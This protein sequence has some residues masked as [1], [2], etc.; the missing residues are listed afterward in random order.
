MPRPGG[1]R[2]TPGGGHHWRW[3]GENAE[4]FAAMGLTDL[5]LPP[6]YKAASGDQS[7]GYDAYDLW[8]FGQFP[9]KGADES[10][11]TTQ[12]KYGD[13]HAFE[14]ALAALQKAG[15]GKIYLDAVLNHRLGADATETF[16]AHPVRDDNR[17]I[18]GDP[19]D[20]DGYT[21]FF[22]PKRIPD[23]TASI[24][25][26][27][28]SDEEP[29]STLQWT[30]NHFTG[31][32]YDQRTEKNQIFRIEGDGKSWAEDVDNENG[33]YDFLMG[34]DVDHAHPAVRKDLF[35]W[36]AWVLRTFPISGMRF[37]AVKHISRDFIR[38]F[39]HHSR[40]VSRDLRKERGQEPADE[41]GGPI[42]FS[43]GELWKDDVPTCLAYLEAFEAGDEGEQF[44]L[45]DA[46]LHYNFVEAGQQGKDYDLRKVFDNT[47]VQVRPRDAVTLVANHDTQPGQA[48][49]SVV[50]PPFVPLAYALIL[51]RQD[52]FP[53]VF[54]GDLDG[55]HGQG[56]GGEATHE[57]PAMAD[58]DKF[59]YARRHFAYGEQRDA[60][61]FAQCVGWA[62]T[63]DNEHDGCAVVIC[64]GDD[65]GRK[66]LDMGAERYKNTTFVDLLGWHQAEVTTGDDGKAE[67]LCPASSVSVWVP[68]HAEAL[69]HVPQGQTE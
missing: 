5:W 14:A 16:L 30:F 36:A 61:D 41:S 54:I 40:Q 9:T 28:Y 17:L 32:D 18:E 63:G 49:E 65:E 69:K 23:G 58:L 39:V 51:L 21:S 31:V 59:I 7:T 29:F 34:A 22:F 35:A 15:I 24:D 62:R 43:V 19:Y 26:P 42:L 64:N 57:V 20:I 56:E 47:L 2:Y 55:C 33:S 37:D 1:S 25:K 67:F 66:V 13:R 3:L 38:D 6:P 12:T 53:C 4:R 45:F 10:P 44:S 50:A 11:N 8:D 46:P 52:G 60:W 27:Q 48:L 68:K